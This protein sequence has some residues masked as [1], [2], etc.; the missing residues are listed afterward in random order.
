MF[1]VFIKNLVKV[2]FCFSVVSSWK[3]KST[4]LDL[5]ISID[6]I[7]FDHF[8]EEVF[9]TDEHSISQSKVSVLGPKFSILWIINDQVLKI[10][11]SI[12]FITNI[13]KLASKSSKFLS[14]SLLVTTINLL[15]SIL[16]DTFMLQCN[17]LVQ[18]LH[19]EIDCGV[20]SLS[21]LILKV[22]VQVSLELISLVFVNATCTN[23]L[24][25]LL[26]SQSK[27]NLLKS[28]TKLLVLE[29]G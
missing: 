1:P 10:L 14:L 8:F 29:I 5:H 19:L 21:H 6:S 16:I 4:H 26:N 13:I 24:F 20:K 23:T 27:N 28:I 17:V 3:Q 18:R 12:L 22:D 25:V 7:N 15:L 2:N 11:L 9:S